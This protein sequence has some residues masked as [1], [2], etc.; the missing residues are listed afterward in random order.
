MQLTCFDAGQ[1]RT[2]IAIDDP[3]E[4]PDGQGGWVRD[5]TERA[6][7]WA[8]EEA[9]ASRAADFAGRAQSVASRRFWIR[10]R[11][12]MRPGQRIRRG[13]RI[14]LIDTADDA[15]GSRRYL[16]LKATEMLP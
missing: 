6:L 5:W 4:T 13:D 16:I 14:F 9:A 1:L 2:M 11:T 15:D 8:H 7:V 3:V 10:F 12:D